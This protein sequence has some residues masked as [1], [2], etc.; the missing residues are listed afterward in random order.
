MGQQA[1]AEQTAGPS[2]TVDVMPDIE[3]EQRAAAS[4]AAASPEVA[5]TP[6][7]ETS[8]KK[9]DDYVAPTESDEP[10]PFDIN[11]FKAAKEGLPAPAPA[12]AAPVTAAPGKQ[13][14]D[15][16]DIDDDL[17]P[18]FK[19]MSN[20]AFEKV[21]P[22]VLEHKKLKAELT[23]KEQA[24][25]EAKK[26]GL[27][28]NY[29]EHEMGY[30]L[31][32]EFTQESSRVQLANAV[33][34][35]WRAQ[36]NAVRQGADT[37]IPLVDDGKGNV[38]Q[39]APIK[40]DRGSDTELTEI[41]LWAQQQAMNAQANLNALAT[42]HKT[43]HTEAKNWIDNFQNR[44]FPIFEK[45]PALKAMVPDTIKIFHPA[46]QNNPLAPVLA[47]AIIAMTK[48]AGMLPK[49]PAAGAPAAPAAAQPATTKQPS[50]AQIAGGAPGAA[51]GAA[52]NGEDNTFELFQKAKKGLL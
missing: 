32:P 35:H 48:L 13:A 23:A 3:A 19:Q 22:I 38:V 28:D 11:A 43:K 16:T 12:A 50:A 29:Y 1:I 37:Y 41:H 40:A 39:G 6:P 44:S 5:A 34:D 15:L 2:T 17:K 27:P 8:T 24:L 10:V 14:R 52:S 42:V 18:L 31:S 7:A 25:A 47:R 46:L 51:A 45:D 49:Q 26:G 33:R 36:L 20:D 30:V 9:A 21:K 4:A